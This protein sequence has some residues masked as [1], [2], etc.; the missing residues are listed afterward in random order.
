ME[1]S[2]NNLH[3]L[4][5]DNLMLFRER[6]EKL[7]F[8]FRPN[9]IDGKLDRGY[10][11]YG[12]Q[13]IAKVS[14]WSSISTIDRD[15]NMS[16]CLTDKYIYLEVK[17]DRSKFKKD[18]LKE[19]ILSNL[20]F[21]PVGEGF[22]GSNYRFELGN[23][24]DLRY[25]L[26]KFLHTIKQQID[27]ELANFKE[28]YRN[29][30]KTIYSREEIDFI[31]E[32]DFLKQ[33]SRVE[34]YRDH[35][36]RSEEFE[37]SEGVNINKPIYLNSFSIKG[38]GILDSIHMKPIPLDN[39]WIFITGENGVGKSLILKALSVFLG[40]VMIPRNL[41]KNKHGKS[42]ASFN[43]ILVSNKKEPIQIE[44][45][46]NE[47]G[48]KFAKSPIV[49]GLACYGIHRMSSYTLS[50]SGKITGDPLLK[51]GITE[52]ILNSMVST[53][54]NL[55]WYLK[56]M[57][58]EEYERFINERQHLIIQ[59]LIEIVPGLVDVHIGHNFRVDRTIYFLQHEEGEVLALDYLE[60]S[61][62]TRS[63]LS[64]VT[65]IFIRFY[66]QQPEMTDPSSFR[67]IVII[68]EIDMHLHPSGQRNLVVNLGRIFPNIQFIVTSH[69]PMPLLG[70]P[71][72]SVFLTVKRSEKGNIELDQLP[73]DFISNLLPNTILTSPLFGVDKIFPR[74]YKEERRLHTEDTYD[75]KIKRDQIRENLKNIA[76]RMKE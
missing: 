52:S 53:L 18:F 38:F 20:E 36:L 25:I 16:F 15:L 70:A 40:R 58:K 14:F 7:F 54:L 35:F 55:E 44:R 68:D 72:S 17:V 5:Y 66:D 67:G 31:S 43:F 22:N 45:Q 65:D 50:K 56:K 73:N 6:D 63:I 59:T 76:N 1:K 24:S 62:G 57:D 26:D 29:E 46:E 47:D 74:S 8:T 28:S 9:N 32:N 60:L 37:R 12:D 61:S 3:E 75:E 30:D 71:E 49:R 42:S 33:K 48:A 27:H 11:F 4:L 69:S 13:N 51:N 39:R 19:R 10:W 64:L 21:R 34:E 23:F 41:S 2:E